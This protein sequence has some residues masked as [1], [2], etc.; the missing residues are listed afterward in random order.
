MHIIGNMLIL[1][2]WLVIKMRTVWDMYIISGIRYWRKLLGFLREPGHAKGDLMHPRNMK[3]PG[4]LPT[5]VCHV[6][7]LLS[8]SWLFQKW[9]NYPCAEFWWL[10]GLVKTLLHL[11][12]VFVLHLREFR[13]WDNFLILVFQWI[14]Q[15]W[16]LGLKLMPAMGKKKAWKIR[17][18]A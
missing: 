13:F 15:N 3:W 18:K 17:K 2:L 1:S 7:A 5:R 11:H 10:L 16:T 14:L 8:C 12:G 6:L 4:L 9:Q